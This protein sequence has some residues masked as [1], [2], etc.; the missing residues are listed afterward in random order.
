MSKLYKNDLPVWVITDT[1]AQVT[2]VGRWVYAGTSGPGNWSIA[3]ASPSPR[4][5]DAAWYWISVRGTAAPLTLTRS[6]ADVFTF[7]GGNQTSLT[8]QPGQSVLLVPAGSNV[9]EVHGWT[10][11]L[12]QVV[13]VSSA[14]TLTL[15][16]DASVYVN[17]GA[18][19]T[20][21]LPALANNTGLTYRIKNRGTGAI[22]LQRAGTDQ[23]YDTAAVTSITIAA[24]ASV[25]IINDGS[26]WL[27]L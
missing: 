14:A 6:N 12:A 22:T 11:S 25:T 23:L 21:T 13:N 1:D 17:T 2:K 10:P 4:S 19:T 8:L 26:Y 9:W 27:S 5:T 7:A 3:P 18:A 20:W 24:G 16:R 15:A